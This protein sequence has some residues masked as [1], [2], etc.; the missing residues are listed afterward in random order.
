MNVV[1]SSAW[2][3]YFANSAHALEFEKPIT[4]LAHLIVPTIVMYEVSKVLLREKQEEIAI[5]AQAHMQQG[6]VVLLT[7][8]LAIDAANKSLTYR[9]PMA[10]SII[11]ATAQAYNATIWTQDEHFKDFA[12]TKYFPGH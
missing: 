5:T 12:K 7:P 4:N 8:S 6:I 10:D 2:L 11:L 9:L 1:D 3:A